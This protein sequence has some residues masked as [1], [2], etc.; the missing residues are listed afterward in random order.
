MDSAPSNATFL[1][2][3]V[4]IL[5]YAVPRPRLSNSSRLIAGSSQSRGSTQQLDART[6]AASIE[7]TAALAP[8]V[9]GPTPAVA[10][11]SKELAEIRR[12]RIRDQEAIQRLDRMWIMSGW[13]VGVWNE[14][15][16]SRQ[17]CVTPRIELKLLRT[18]L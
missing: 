14:S 2:V 11:W 6:D 8:N 3:D 5:R 16:I 12:G 10:T 1:H 15:L 13:L 7:D 9:G 17:G 4:P 18:K